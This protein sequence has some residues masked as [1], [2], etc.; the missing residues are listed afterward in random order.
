MSYTMECLKNL[1]LDRL[2]LSGVISQNIKRNRMS[3]VQIKVTNI[4]G[5]PIKGA[6]I[7][8][9]QTDSEFKFGCNAFMVNQFDNE[10]AN[11]AYTEKFKKVFNQAVV[12]FFGQMMNPKRGNIVLKKAVR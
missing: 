2:G 5:E 8:V 9:N 4:K 1:D 11:D 10:K 6:K 3:S 12:P 7:S